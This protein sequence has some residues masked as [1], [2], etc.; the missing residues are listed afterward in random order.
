VVN[1][2]ESIV[3]NP[4]AKLHVRNRFLHREGNINT[5]NVNYKTQRSLQYVC[6]EIEILKLLKMS[7]D[8]ARAMWTV[9]MLCILCLTLISVIDGGGGGHKDFLR[10]LLGQSCPRISY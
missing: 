8:L 5:I 10:D 3:F 7:Y 4:V 2:V 1:S 6:K 9:F